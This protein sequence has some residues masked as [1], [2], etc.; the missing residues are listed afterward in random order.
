MQT[1]YD[2]YFERATGYRRYA[3]QRRFATAAKLPDVVCAPTGAGKTEAVVCGWLWRTRPEAEP[4]RPTLRRLVIALPMRVLAEQTVRR[5]ENILG[6]LGLSEE[7][8]VTQLLGGASYDV[9]HAWT[10]HPERRQI[11]IGTVDMLVSRALN[12]G[13]ADGRAA[14]PVSF[15]LLNADVLWVF[16]EVQLLDAALITSGQLDVFRRD[17]AVNG[18]GATHGPAALSVWMSATLMP[19]WLQTVDR[20]DIVGLRSLGLSDED[21]CEPLLS[22][23][24]AH[25]TVERLPHA[26]DDIEATARAVVAAHDEI[27]AEAP[28]TLVLCNTVKRALDVADALDRL[29]GPEVEKLVLHSRFR[30]PDRK[31]AVERLENSISASGGRIVV[32]TQ[33]IEAGLD[34]DAHVL[35]TESCPVASLIQRLGRLNRAGKHS[36]GGRLLWVSPP[37]PAPYD[38]Q[39]VAIAEALLERLDDASPDALAQAVEADPELLGAPPEALVLRRDD[40]EELFD[41]SPTLD[42]DETDIRAFIRLGEDHDAY[43]VWR[44]D[45]AG[46]R[47]RPARDELCP[48]PLAEARELVKA[49]E[50]W[51]W[52]YVDD[53]W[54]RLSSRTALRPGVVV[55]VG[56]EAGRYDAT[57]GWSPTA[58]EPVTALARP[59]GLRLE[60]DQHDPDSATGDWIRLHDHTEAVVARTEQIVGALGEAL[61][62]TER[63]AL[64]ITAVWHDAGKA[65][66]VMAARLAGGKASAA[67]GVGGDAVYAKSGPPP[68]PGDAP[69]VSEDDARRSHGRMRHEVASVLALDAAGLDLA[70]ATLRLARYLVGAHHGKLRLLARTEVAGGGAASSGSGREVLGVR[71]GDAFG[72][73][74]PLHG[75]HVVPAVVADLELFTLG[76]L[77]CETWTESALELVAEVG[78]FRLAWLEALLRGADQLVSAQERA[79][80]ATAAEGGSA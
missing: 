53:K 12:R 43:V 73:D 13:Y 60:A 67:G 40:L 30:P 59:D 18:Y 61:T 7:V 15:G 10:L 6:R 35:V 77:E 46:D 47:R 78:A 49:V 42:G 66:P 14:W 58:R 69:V 50:A 8:T 19:E 34:L 64:T 27:T 36:G 52:S 1:D 37:H 76:S 4:A 48:V 9:R 74:I 71:D 51:R 22:R 79:A 41:T 68:V 21:R 65:H 32:S 44:D 29:A 5:V 75:S 23:L 26:G 70:P 62:E 39:A 20:P 2:S 28:F 24:R 57:S 80:A 63:E 31:V 11:L 38:P 25:K 45:P 17:P 72:G 33:V 3:Y 55:V 54:E 56:V 16:D